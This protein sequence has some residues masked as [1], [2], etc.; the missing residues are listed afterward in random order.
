MRMGVANSLFVADGQLVAA[1]RTAA[2][3]N[4]A[5]VFGLHTLA[6]A[7]LFGAFAVVR[8]ECTFRHLILSRRAQRI[9]AQAQTLGVRIQYSREFG[10]VRRGWGTLP[11][12][13]SQPNPTSIRVCCLR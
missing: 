13:G 6:E 1:T 8:L 3:E 11:H 7:M 9:R 4:G 10:E 5:P 12:R 2:G